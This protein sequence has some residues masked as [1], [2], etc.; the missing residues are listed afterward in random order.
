ML[1]KL[2]ESDL[3]AGDAAALGLEPFTEAESAALGL[4]RTGAGFQIPYFD[5]ARKRLKMFR[6]R[7]F[8]TEYQSGFLKGEKLRKY[9]QP[10]KTDSEI[11][12]PTLGNVTWPE[13]MKDPGMP[14]IITEGELKAA[15]GTKHVMPTIG[16]GGVWSFGSKKRG[17]EFLPALDA[18][19]W[20]GRTVIIC[21]DSD[22]VRKPDVVGAENRLA[23]RLVDLNAIVKIVRLRADSNQK[24]GLD[25]YIVKHGAKVFGELLQQTEEWL[26]S[27]ALHALNEKVIFVKY[28]AMMVEYPNDDHPA[29][30]QLYRT[31]TRD[32][33]ARATYANHKH[34]VSRGEKQVQVKT[35]EEWIEWPGRAQVDSIT[36]KPGEPVIVNGNQLNTWR[37]ADV[38]PCEGDTAP[39]QELLAHLIPDK[40]EREIFECAMA[41][42]LQTPGLR[43]NFAVMMWGEREGTG[44]TMVGATI[45]ALHGPTNYAEITQTELQ[46]SFNPWQAHKTLIMGSELC[47]EKDSRAVADR[48]KTIITGETVTVNRKHQPEYVLPNHA[49]FYLTSNHPNAVYIGEHARRFFVLH[50]EAVPL[51]SKFYADFVRWRDEQ[52]GL[53]ALYHRLLTKDLQGFDAKGHAPRTGALAEMIA[54]NRTRIQEWAHELATNKETVLMRVGKVVPGCFFTSDELLRIFRSRAGEQSMVSE[55]ALAASLRAVGFKQTNQVRIGGKGSTERLRLWIIRDVPGGMSA[56]EIGRSYA[57][58]RCVREPWRRATSQ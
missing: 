40:E 23:R 49:N 16:L 58:E 4:S 48:L 14:L 24:V 11:Y 54:S 20:K 43:L 34:F 57:R 45:G 56:T 15:C 41:A 36:Y 39:W 47:G 28:P 53:A 29:D 55:K 42:P 5:A 30:Q 1:K 46:S 26:P 9:D 13:V 38:R 19:T 35:A 27:A 25:D 21:F 37:A 17:R 44:K 52:G 8:D 7:Y 2:A 51:P 50:T 33:F 10:A 31:M 12:L 18:F 32:T 22:A 6:F 3:D